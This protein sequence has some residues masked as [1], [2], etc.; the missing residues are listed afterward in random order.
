[1][2][3]PGQ[4]LEPRKLV[5][6][7]DWLARDAELPIENGLASTVSRLGVGPGIGAGVGIRAARTK[8]GCIGVGV[9]AD[10]ANFVLCADEGLPGDEQVVGLR[11]HRIIVPSPNFGPR[12]AVGG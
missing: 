12:V 6:P 8:K 10:A 1:M 11:G 3:S 9:V 2:R 4:L 7:L 5:L